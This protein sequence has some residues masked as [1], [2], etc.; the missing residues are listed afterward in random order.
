MVFL[1]YGGTL[2]ILAFYYMIFTAKNQVK[3]LCFTLH[4]RDCNS[5]RLVYTTLHMK[6]P[7]GNSFAIHNT[8]VTFDCCF[9]ILNVIIPAKKSFL[10]EENLGHSI[11]KI[12]SKFGHSSEFRVF[13]LGKSREF[14]S[15]FAPWKCLLTIFFSPWPKFFH[16]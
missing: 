16:L 9:R 3:Q 10:E 13:F 6:A 8:A 15:E 5:N 4:Y 14:S 12:F 1:C 11:Q 2:R 7:Q